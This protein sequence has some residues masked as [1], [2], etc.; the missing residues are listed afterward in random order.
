[1]ANFRPILPKPDSESHRI[2]KLFSK[3]QEQLLLT[4][5]VSNE[6]EGQDFRW[7]IVYSENDIVDAES[8]P[9]QAAQILI[10]EDGIFQFQ[11]FLV[12]LAKGKVNDASFR[13]IFCR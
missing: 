9:S 5:F 4:G 6:V 13:G 1:M 12:T 11:V 10:D 8:G 7:L 3:L 2:N